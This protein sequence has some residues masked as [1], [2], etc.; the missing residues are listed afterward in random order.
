[1]FGNF[2]YLIVVLLIYSTYP[3]SENTNFP[4]YETLLLFLGLILLFVLANWI[5][6]FR[7]HGRISRD[8]LSRL[9]H[10]FNTLVTRQSVMA[11]ILFA[12]DVYGLNLPSFLSGS[13]LFSLIP[14]AQALLFLGL[15]I[16]YLSVVW[17][18]AY[19]VQYRIYRTDLSKASYIL[20][21]I[22]ISVPLLIPWLVLSGLADIINALPYPSA[23]QFLLTP[24]GQMLYFLIFLF[25]IAILG[26]G[27]IQKFWRC[28]PLERG[29]Y[30]DRIEGVCNAAG[31]AYSNILHWPIF[32]G[33]MITAGVMGLIRRFRY[34]L[35][36]D[37]LLRHLKPE[38][39]D[40]VLAG[41]ED[42]AAPQTA[43]AL[44]L[45]LHGP[46]A[47]MVWRVVKA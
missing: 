28:K 6:F 46:G 2:L 18:F 7:L 26:P 36:T 31:L 42:H 34:I 22:S 20:S 37:G 43:R 21:N 44:R 32:G 14:T 25:G 29:Y 41:G 35:V 15:F 12:F 16:F 5:S 4:G 45:R 24:E 33:Q 38:E 27:M 39:I 17:A 1:M 23:R 11:V 10:R 40:A 30:R 47:F 3:P 9:D 19:D 8:P 13:P